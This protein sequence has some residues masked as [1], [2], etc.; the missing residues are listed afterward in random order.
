MGLMQI[1][2]KSFFKFHEVV[3]VTGV[4]PYV[5]RYWE[6]EFE[7]ISPINSSSGEKLYEQ[8]DLEL[9]N[10][11]KSYLF[12]DKLTIDEA[13]AKLKDLSE[14]DGSQ[15]NNKNGFCSR[16]NTEGEMLVIDCL[17]DI[18]ATISLIKEKHNWD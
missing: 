11:I 17:K 3:G 10:S 12:D 15:A 13:K 2:R 18:V 14:K 7:Q 16:E 6:S 1:P 5:L 9:F 8:K 4:K